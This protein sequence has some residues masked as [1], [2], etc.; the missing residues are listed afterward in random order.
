MGNEKG[1]VL[2]FS[3]ITLTLTGATELSVSMELDRFSGYGS[4]GYGFRSNCHLKKNIILSIN[5]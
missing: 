5:S 2:R 4:R 3:E 1:G